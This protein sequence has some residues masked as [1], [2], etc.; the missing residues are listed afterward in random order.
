MSRTLYPL[1]VDLRGKPVLMAGGGAVAARKLTELLRCGADITV[2]APEPS[3]A[4]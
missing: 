1:A 3:P 4:D 2:I